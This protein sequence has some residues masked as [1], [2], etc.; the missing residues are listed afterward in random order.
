MEFPIFGWSRWSVHASLSRNCV[1]S[2]CVKDHVRASLQ[3]GLCG[4]FQDM[5]RW[6]VSFWRPV[7]S[8]QFP[9][10]G[11]M[12]L[13]FCC[14]SEEFARPGRR[15]WA[16]PSDAGGETHPWTKRFTLDTTTW[17]P[18]SKTTTTSTAPRT[19]PPTSRTQRRTWTV[20]CDEELWTNSTIHTKTETAPVHLM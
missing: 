20:C 1:E 14:C 5:L 2:K 7:K 17:W 12:E 15:D 16:C 19:R 6:F 3:N 11:N 18:Y 4:V 10:T 13:T 9:E 8:T